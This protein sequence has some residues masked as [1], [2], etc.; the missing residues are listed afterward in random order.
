MVLISDLYGHDLYG[1][2]D[3]S[4]G[5]ANGVVFLGLSIADVEV[6]DGKMCVTAGGRF[7]YVCSCYALPSHSS[8]GFERLLGN[9]VVSDVGVDSDVIVAG[10]FNAILWLGDRRNDLSGEELTWVYNH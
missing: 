4:G 6:G 7:F 3:S 10:D 8:V 5:Q 9:V 1:W 2:Y